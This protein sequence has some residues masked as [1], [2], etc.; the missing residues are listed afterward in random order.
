M[1]ERLNSLS[2]SLSIENNNPE[3]LSYLTGNQKVCGQNIQE[4]RYY[5]KSQVVHFL[6]KMLFGGIFFLYISDI[7]QL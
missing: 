2:S 3:S 7:F 6:K 1:A 5:R 4:K